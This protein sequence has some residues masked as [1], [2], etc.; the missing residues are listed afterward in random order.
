MHIETKGFNTK[1]E[2]RDFINS[3]GIQKDNIVAF[4]QELDETYTVVFY[5]E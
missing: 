1:N 2:A 3:Q 5:A 4:F